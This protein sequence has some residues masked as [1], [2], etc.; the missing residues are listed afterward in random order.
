VAWHEQDERA[1]DG[2]PERWVDRL[3]NDGSRRGVL[4]NITEIVARIETV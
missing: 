1:T 3:I 4:D 2:E